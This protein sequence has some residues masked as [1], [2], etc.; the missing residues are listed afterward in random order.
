[1]KYR[2]VRYR[3]LRYRFRFVSRPRLDTNIPSFQDVFK[4]SSRH[5]FKTSS[6]HVFKRSSR[7]LQR[8]IFSSSKSSSRRLA[9]CLQDVFKT[10][11]KTKNCY[12]ED[13][14]KM[15]SRCL[16]NQQTFAGTQVLKENGYQENIISKIF[17][18]VTN[19]NSFSQSQQQTQTTDI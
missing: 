9:G 1:M 18:R 17:K 15:S 13:E 6:R 19:N 4:K 12:A 5:I 8:N 2:F 14:L 7:R 11:W 3:F 16:E 10:S